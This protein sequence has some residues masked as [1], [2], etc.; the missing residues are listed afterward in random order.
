M[1][2]LFGIEKTLILRSDQREEREIRTHELEK[3]C[4]AKQIPPKDESEK[5]RDP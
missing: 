5:E 2:R 3:R 1:W 4:V